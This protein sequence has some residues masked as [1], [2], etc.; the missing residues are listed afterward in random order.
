[1]GFG[2]LFSELNNVLF[3]ASLSRVD[4]YIQLANQF[5]VGND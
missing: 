3:P 2:M 1:M 4:S 5:N